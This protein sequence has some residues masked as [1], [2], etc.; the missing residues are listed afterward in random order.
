MAKEREEER[1]FTIPLRISLKAPRTKR[2]P[3][4]V[5]AVREYVA[6]HMNAEL[7]KVII[8]PE[9]NERLWYRGIQ[10][11]PVRIIVKALW[12]PETE[13]VEVTLPKV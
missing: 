5:K 13:E 6:R 4:A 1:Q 11:P 2:T 10:R 8:T 3:R 12:L 7:D 9:V